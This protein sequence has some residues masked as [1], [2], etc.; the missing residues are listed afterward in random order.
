MR[1][2]PS[3]KI[4]S[5]FF[6]ITRGQAQLIRSVM[7]SAT[8]NKAIDSAMGSL[9]TLLEGYGVEA[10][11]GEWWTN[12]FWLDINLLYVNMGDTYTGTILYDPQAER[13]ILSSWGDFV[14]RHPERVE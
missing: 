6:G 7:D 8:N 11:R 10:F 2:K 12:V 5:G 4:I 3:I 1:Y 9:N 13:F 14:E